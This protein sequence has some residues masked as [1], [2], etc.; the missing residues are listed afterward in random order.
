MPSNPLLLEILNAV[1]PAKAE[2]ITVEWRNVKWT[3]TTFLSERDN[4]WVDGKVPASAAGTLMVM[5]ILK[6]PELAAALRS[7]N[8]K[9]TR[10]YMADEVEEKLKG[11]RGG[12]ASEEDINWYTMA[13]TR[14][15]VHAWLN[16]SFDRDAVNE[17]YNLYV[18]Q[19]R[20]PAEKKRKDFFASSTETPPTPAGP[21]GT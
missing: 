17:L 5:S 9:P 19:V 13:V 6:T 14:D 8:G 15:A 11:V 18:S 20:E 2:E 7:I 16:E 10:T 3:F 12:G 21:Q 1:N 4:L